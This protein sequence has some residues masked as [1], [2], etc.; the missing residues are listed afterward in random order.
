MDGILGEERIAIFLG[1]YIVMLFFY[2]YISYCMIK[3]SEK[4]AFP[5]WAKVVI[6]VCGLGIISVGVLFALNEGGKE[7]NS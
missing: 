2:I 7:F 4:K 5:L 6:G 3:K 1:I